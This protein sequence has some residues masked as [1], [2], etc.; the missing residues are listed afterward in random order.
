VFSVP[1]GERWIVKQVDV[2]SFS[3]L[4]V[5][6]VWAINAGDTTQFRRETVAA[7]ASLPARRDWFVVDEL[8]DLE[9]E[10]SALSG[11]YVLWLV[12]G[13]RLVL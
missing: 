11:G 2:A 7:G 8:Q 5:A 13:T 4:A 6:L 1:A 9:V 3:S 12:S 10:V